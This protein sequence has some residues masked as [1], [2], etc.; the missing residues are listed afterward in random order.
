M[1]EQIHIAAWPG[2]ST[3]MHNPHCCIFNAV[4][5]A[6]ARHHALAGQTFVINVQSPI[7][8]DAIEQMGFREKPDMIRPGGGWTAIVG[9]DGQIISGPLTDTEGILYGEIDLERIILCK[10]ACDSAGHYARPDVLRLYA[11]LR[12]QPVWEPRQPAEGPSDAPT[13]SLPEPLPAE[14]ELDL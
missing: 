14:T 3:L 7:G 6:A 12:P 8:E 9:P 11:D 5:D 4:T 10:Y 13:A 2:V 1:G